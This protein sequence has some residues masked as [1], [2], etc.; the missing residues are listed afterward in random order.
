MYM[1]ILQQRGL[2]IKCLHKSNVKARVPPTDETKV[3]LTAPRAH[4]D[5]EL[6]T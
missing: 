6:L 5:K 1:Y 4:A 2:E 3:L